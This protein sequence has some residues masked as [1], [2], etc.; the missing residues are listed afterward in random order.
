[1]KENIPDGIAPF[2][3][4]AANVLHSIDSDTDTVWPENTSGDH[5]KYET[6]SSISAGVNLDEGVFIPDP[7][8]PGTEGLSHIIVHTLMAD[9]D[10]S[11]Q[12]AM[13]FSQEI[14]PVVHNL[15]EYEN[16][17]VSPLSENEIRVLHADFHQAM[18]WLAKK[19]DW[20][21]RVDEWDFDDRTW[22]DRLMLAVS[23]I[24]V[25]QSYGACVHFIWCLSTPWFHRMSDIVATSSDSEDL[26]VLHPALRCLRQRVYHFD[27]MLYGFMENAG[28][29][30][31]ELYETLEDGD[32]LS[33]IYDEESEE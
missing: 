28:S 16:W 4:W 9:M 23:Y 5:L 32:M 1:M 29:G 24:L 11:F 6:K 33:E 21:T 8:N 13:R 12:D 20:N 18:S 25:W 22:A 10:A 14:I 31:D 7:Y 3:D 15:E 2:F 19:N 30:I 17:V 27:N 26:K